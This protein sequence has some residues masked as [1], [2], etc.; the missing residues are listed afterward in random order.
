MQPVSKQRILNTPITIGVLLETVLT[1]WSVQCG[2]EEEFSWESAIEFRSSKWE[3]SREL[4]RWS[5][6]FRCGVLTSEKRIEHG[7]WKISLNRSR[8][9]ETAGGDCNWLRTVVCVCQRSVSC[10]FLWCVQVVNK[11][12][13][14][15]PYPIH[16][17]TT[18]KTGQYVCGYITEF[19]YVSERTQFVFLN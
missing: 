12:I 9:Q 17:H 8:C 18:L 3:V 16:I 6:E 19:Y 11:F 5:W 4:G 10:G 15:N 14:S 2:Y 13:S 1:N 7:S